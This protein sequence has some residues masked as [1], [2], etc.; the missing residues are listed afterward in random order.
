VTFFRLRALA[1]AP[2]MGLTTAFVAE[3]I[4]TLVMAIG[5]DWLLEATKDVPPSI[6]IPFPRHPLGHLVSTAGPEHIAE[7]LELAE[8]LH[9]LSKVPGVSSV[10]QA[11]RA[12]Y[13]QTV[14]QVAFAARLRRGGAQNLVLEPTATDGRLSDIRFDFG[15]MRY[16][17]RVLSANVQ[18]RRGSD[19]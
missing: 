1:S 14:L 8:Y 5:R 17:A 4:D 10:P 2:S 16:R 11:L 3:Q 19:T 7:A 9:A 12:Q 18:A 13:Y 6:P 15:G